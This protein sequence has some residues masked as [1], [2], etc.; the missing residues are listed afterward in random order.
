VLKRKSESKLM[1]AIARLPVVPDSFM[2]SF[3]TTVGQTIYVPAQHDK[4]EDWGTPAWR[5]RH[6][7]V[8]SHE[9]VHVDQFRRWSVPLMALGYIGPAPFLLPFCWLHWGV[10]VSMIALLPLSCGLAYFRWRIERRA[11]LRNLRA[12]VSSERIAETL[13]HDYF[14][15]WPPKWVVKWFSRQS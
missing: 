1:R 13:W 15:T 10:L 5:I 7:S 8:I 3:W 4:D 11:Y 14:Y 6:A 9:L 12:G 2:R